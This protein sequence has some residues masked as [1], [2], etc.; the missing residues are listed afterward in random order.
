MARLGLRR[1]RGLG[2]QRTEAAGGIYRGDDIDE[3]LVL[4]P[5]DD[6]SER[7]MSPARDCKVASLRWRT[8]DGR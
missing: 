4:Y 2:E 6:A 8:K 1:A 5:S 7:E 3:A